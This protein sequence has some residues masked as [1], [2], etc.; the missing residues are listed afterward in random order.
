MELSRFLCQSLLLREGALQMLTE[1]LEKCF[2]IVD[3]DGKQ[4]PDSRNSA[5]GSFSLLSW[6]LPVFQFFML[7]FHSKASQHNPRKH[8]M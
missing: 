8:D 5:K 1:V 2:A 7:L 6:C 4:I 3:V